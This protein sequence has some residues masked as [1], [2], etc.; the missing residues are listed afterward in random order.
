M[1]GAAMAMP[2]GAQATEH[3]AAAADEGHCAD[4]G[5]QQDNGSQSFDFDCRMACAGVLALT[6]SIGETPIVATVPRIMAV[7]EPAVGS[8]PAAE[9]R[10]PRL[11]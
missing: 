5:G 6:P 7:V 10:P 9:P 3:H 1:G 4:M 2:T 8:S 11:S